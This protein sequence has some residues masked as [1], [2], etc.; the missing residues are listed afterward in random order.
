MQNWNEHRARSQY[1]TVTPFKPVANSITKDTETAVKFL[2]NMR[3]DAESIHS[4]FQA[5]N[6]V[7]HRALRR[8]RDGHIDTESITMMR[9]TRYDNGDEILVLTVSVAASLRYEPVCVLYFN[10]MS[11][12]FDVHVNHLFF[13]FIFH[14][15]YCLGA[16]CILHVSPLPKMGSITYLFQSLWMQSGIFGMCTFHINSPEINVFEKLWTHLESTEEAGGPTIN[17]S[18]SVINDAPMYHGSTKDSLSGNFSCIIK[19]GRDIVIPLEQLVLDWTLKMMNLERS[20]L[21]RGAEIDRPRCLTSSHDEVDEMKDD[22]KKYISEF[23]RNQTKLYEQDY[24]HEL[25][26]REM[27][28]H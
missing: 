23:P 10:I 14:I 18:R 24:I 15:S 11:S 17:T 22:V 3:V 6:E 26:Y 13:I 5:P 20:A 21:E 1:F 12:V 9:S 8:L 2:T 28:R 25:E 16:K 7:Y 27:Y 19:S 4:M